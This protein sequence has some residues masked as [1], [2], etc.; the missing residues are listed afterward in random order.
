MSIKD[1]RNKFSKQELENLLSSTLV[2]VEPD[3]QFVNRLKGR[4]VKIHGRKPFTV[5]TALALLGSML[6]LVAMALGVAL[7]FLLAGM[8][9]INLIFQK[10]ALRKGAP[11][12]AGI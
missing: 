10:R 6:L 3:D 2:P 1:I 8:G 12:S 11:G 5:W 4:L 9:L 7:R